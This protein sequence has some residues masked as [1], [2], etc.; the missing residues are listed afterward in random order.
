[1][2]P[3]DLFKKLKSILGDKILPLQALYLSGGEESREFAERLATALYLNNVTGIRGGSR[4]GR[5]L[6]EC[7]RQ[8]HS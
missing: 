7:V 8:E 6:Q 1:M 3:P 4:G 2:L 5:R